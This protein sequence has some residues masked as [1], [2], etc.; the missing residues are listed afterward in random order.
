ML[1]GAAYRSF[2]DGLPLRTRRTE[3]PLWGCCLALKLFG[4]TSRCFNLLLRLLVELRS[5]FLQDLVGV[6]MGR[7][8]A[9]IMD[10]S[11]SALLR[12]DEG[13]PGPC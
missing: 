5:V 1:R 6:A 7:K 11:P 12:A 13:S 3:S 4:T 8:E 9:D 2:P 10:L